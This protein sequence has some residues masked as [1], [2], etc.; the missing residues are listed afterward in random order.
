MLL[1]EKC[2]CA[3]LI[4]L[5]YIIWPLERTEEQSVNEKSGEEGVCDEIPGETSEAKISGKAV[6]S[7]VSGI[8][9]C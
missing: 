5:W 7:A 8:I 6:V 9:T 2:H 4:Y 3:F 1:E